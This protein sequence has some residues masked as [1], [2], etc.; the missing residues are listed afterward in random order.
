MLNTQNISV[1]FGKGLQTKVDPKLVVSGDMT[2]LEN[3]VFTKEG[4]IGKAPGHDSFT[5]NKAGGGTLSAPKGL[6][7]YQSE[8]VV[9]DSGRLYSYSTQINAWIDKGKYVPSKVTNYY[10]SRGALSDSVP[11]VAYS[12]NIAL[13]A[14]STN[15]TAYYKAVDV[16]T[17]TVVQ[18][19]TQ[20]GGANCVPMAVK[21]GAS[22][23]ALVY[24]S[25]QQL[26]CSTITVSISGVVLGPPHTIANNVAKDPLQYCTTYDAATTSGGAVIA[27][28]SG[29]TYSTTATGLGLLTIDTTGTLVNSL[30][31]D[32]GNG[33]SQPRA[34]VGPNGNSWFYWQHAT[35]TPYQMY[36]AIYNSSLSVVL[37]QTLIKTSSDALYQ[38]TAIPT[39]NT[40]QT[41]YWSTGGGGFGVSAPHTFTIALDSSGVVPPSGTQVLSGVVIASDYF[42]VGSNNYMAFG[43]NSNSKTQGTFFILDLSDYKVVAKAFY[44]KWTSGFAVG[45][46][47]TRN[48]RPVNLSSTKIL[49]PTLIVEQLDAFALGV[50]TQEGVAA[51]I[52]EFNHQDSYQALTAQNVQVWNGGVVK[53]YDGTQMVELGFHHFPEAP[54]LSASGSGSGLSTA[55]YQYFAVYR[56]F[57]SQGNMHLSAPSPAGKV[58]VTSGQNVSVTVPYLYLTDKGATGGA[59]PNNPV[60]ILVYRTAPTIGGSVA[61]LITSVTTPYTNNALGDYLIFTD[62]A[63][64]ASISNN[65]I[66]YS[67]PLTPGS[68]VENIAPPPSVLMGSHNNRVYLVSSEDSSVWY[69]KTLQD[70][71]GVSFSDLFAQAVDARGGD[72]TA[73]ASIDANF[74]AFKSNLMFVQA[75]DGPNDTGSGSTLTNFQLVP[76]DIGCTYSKSVIATPMGLLIK[77]QKGIYLADRSLSVSYIGK[78]VEAYNSQSVTAAVLLSDRSQVRFLTDSGFTLIFDYLYNKWSTRT[79]HQGYAADVWNGVYVYLRT[80][81]NIYKEN[82]STYLDNG[83]AYQLRAQTSWLKLGSVQ[84][85]QRVRRVALLGDFTGGSGHGVQISAAYDYGTSFSTPILYSLP[86]SSGTFQYRERLPQQKCESIQ[87]LIEE[88]TTGA[89]GEFVDFTDLTFEAGIKQ[90]I[91]KLPAAQS[92]G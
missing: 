91:N 55:A 88:V 64:D 30:T 35:P 5:L 53:M 33:V 84:G 28:V 24:N 68:V 11:S 25:N 20:F 6:K 75:G 69:S 57:D 58:S 9:A 63:S 10:I 29:P 22:Q 56:W 39:S 15:G 13:Y 66:L 67:N 82:T 74:V 79:N 14:W 76:T 18:P 4:Q 62:S 77:T 32:V 41:F 73:I 38:Y 54:I 81:G 3:A 52:F 86:N 50:L 19:D 87:L 34:I 49:I 83:A 44:G 71:V 61:Y 48:V 43:F 85:F 80:D 26:F 1:N 90:G 46:Y 31:I 45:G 37:A 40:T 65:E 7:S 12:N 42:T 8:L 21:L 17:N 70:G 92:V 16:T 78:D 59:F 89:S 72:V 51:A 47:G 36:Y 27:Y 60:Q 2:R 23:L